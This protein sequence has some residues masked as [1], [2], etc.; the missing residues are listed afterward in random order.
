MWTITENKNW[1]QLEAQFNWVRDMVTIPQ[2]VIH[3]AEGNVAIHT[4]MVLDALI[5]HPACQLLAP[6]EKEVLWA[7]A[8]LHDVEK[9]STTVTEPDGRI[10]AHGHARKG[11]ATA[12]QVLYR[13]IETPFVIREMIC[14]L[15]RHHSLPLWLLERRDPLQELVSASME[16]NTQ[17]LALLARADVTGRICHD[18]ADLLYRIDCFEEFCKEHNCWGSTRTF[19]SAHARF[20]YLQHA[21]AHA[22]YVPFEQPA[23][24]VIMMSGLP[25]A[26]KDTF[27]KKHY[28]QHPVISLDDIREEMQIDATDKSGN[29]Q[30][31]QAAKEK[32]RGYLRK[33]Q[34]FVWNATNTTR[35]MRTQLI[36]LFLTYKAAVKIEYVEVP[37]KKL[38]SQNKSRETAVPPAAMEKLVRKLEVPAPWEAQAVNYHTS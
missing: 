25:G 12:R 24:Q 17:W 15:V 18:Q 33:Q 36:S 20:H 32:A 14:G 31:I 27:V 9:R 16:V 8:L 4:Q 21:G 23:F 35:Q 29:G 2:D 1:P 11:A 30:A 37:Y 28:P 5:Q 26:G 13:D 6:Q 38:L 3:H 19:A 10:T 22:D 7:A 34:S